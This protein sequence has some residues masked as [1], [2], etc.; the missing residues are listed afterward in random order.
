[1]P[2]LWSWWQR[3]GGIALIGVI[4]VLSGLPAVAVA[5]EI[6]PFR[7]TGIEGF[8]SLRT[9][10]E[11]NT[12]KREVGEVKTESRQT[13]RTF[14]EELY[15]LTHNYIFHPN[16]LKLDLGGGVVFA[17][18]RFESDGQAR[19]SEDIFYN[20]TGRLTLLEKKPY[21]LSLFYDRLTV[22][23]SSGLA[24][25]FFLTQSKYGL[26][27]AFLEPLAP[28]PLTL[29][30]FQQTEKGEGSSQIRDETVTQVNVQMHKT[31]PKKSG[32][33]S[34]TYQFERQDSASG[35]RLTPIEKSRITTHAGD[36]T[37]TYVFGSRRQ[38]QVQHLFS[39]F[40]QG[41][42]PARRDIQ[43]FLTLN[44]QLTD[45]LTGFANYNL[46]MNRT[47]DVSTISHAARVGFSHQLY[48][49]VSTDVDV[50]ID[51]SDST[52]LQTRIVGVGGGVRY[53]KKTFFGSLSLHYRALYDINDRRS[54]A[55]EIQVFSERHVLTGLLPEELN[56]DNVIPSTVRVFNATR[57]M[58]FT[59]GVDY[60]LTVVGI[61]TRI[62]RLVDS[63]IQ[64]GEAVLVDYAHATTGTFK[65]SIFDQSY[66]VRLDFFSY[67]TLFARFRNTSQTLLAGISLQ[68][69]NSITSQLY[70]LRFYLP[71]QDAFVVGGDA[72]YE[73]HEE[74][75]SSFRRT[76]YSWFLQLP[77][78][79][80]TVF[81]ANFSRVVVDNLDS[82][83]DVNAIGVRLRL[84]SRPWARARFS[85]EAS[86]DRDTGGTL[87]REVR[88]ATVLGEW[89][90]RQLILHLEGQFGQERQGDVERDKIRFNVEIHREF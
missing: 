9:L 11:E 88:L 8:V 62:E 24:E 30:A 17:Q 4:V 51:D 53:Q 16:F 76:S 60:R 89:R 23:V 37:A 38:V 79:A 39:V 13:Q 46:R 45:A 3:G 32:N 21:P 66:G 61:T 33:A 78:A 25:R 50:H 57:S 48:E 77:L 67:L 58:T 31:F 85:A 27:F 28:A 81:F 26:N 80:S 44:W 70:G 83:E 34:L 65:L 87:E 52:G 69:L 10:F 2:W 74:D 36:Y 6:A 20:A 18:E 72:E 84:E 68:P 55:A 19:A 43:K 63:N 75:I 90:F 54:T 7:L 1:M 35:N 82:P 14:E 64:D 86:F 22:P 59:E 15:F 40:T 47:E 56:N 73:N 71:I 42:F 49:S 5:Q 29:E 41:G 12:S